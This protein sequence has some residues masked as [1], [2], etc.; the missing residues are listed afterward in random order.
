MKSA[1]AFVVSLGPNLPGL[2]N[3][4]SPSLGLKGG[5]VHLWDVNYLYGF[6]VAVFIYVSLNLVFPAQEISSRRRFRA[7]V[8]SEAAD[9]ES[10]IESVSADW[11]WG[12]C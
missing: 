9:L 10:D 8:W 2:A 11:K 7:I 12:Y 4:V 1:G 6:Y 5:I 3:S